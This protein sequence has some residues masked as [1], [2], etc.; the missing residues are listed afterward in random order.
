MKLHLGE[1][2][3]ENRRRMGL[4]QEQLA[5]R[6]GVSFHSVSRWEN[7]TTYPDME[8]LPE[9]AR[10]FDTTT[11]AL[12]GF[13]EKE[14]KIPIA[15]LIEEFRDACSFEKWDVCIR[16]LKTLRRDYLK[17]VMEHGTL[18]LGMLQ[19]KKGNEIPAVM[20]EVRIFWDA[21]LQN[22]IKG[23]NRGALIQRIVNLENEERVQEFLRMYSSD[24]YDTTRDTLLL[25][26]YHSRMEWEKYKY[27]YAIKKF[28][29]FGDFLFYRFTC[30]TADENKDPFYWAGINGQK[31]RMINELSGLECRDEYPVSGDGE[32][33]IF[34]E[35]RIEIGFLY[36]Y[37]LC[38]CGEYDRALTVFEDMT[39]L[40]EKLIEMPNGEILRN[41]SAMFRDLNVEKSNRR[42]SVQGIISDVVFFVYAESDIG[43]EGRY[44]GYMNTNYAQRLSIKQIREDICS[45]WLNPVKDNPRYKEIQKRLDDCIH[46]NRRDDEIDIV[47]TDYFMKQTD[48]GEKEDKK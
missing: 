32:I 38:G 47:C 19:W 41:H 28:E 25:E 20:D 7:G 23:S 27:L 26:R 36:A 35:M 45:E 9:I 21:C 10:L 6:L 48:T 1:N 40:F 34:A 24:N 17:E 29:L 33:D 4:T 14:E 42:H 11:D 39:S 5:D 44:C 13:V 31:L 43:N 2:I 16:I 3:R 18:F 15:E 46:I 12:L 8:K 30:G 37:Q 22:G